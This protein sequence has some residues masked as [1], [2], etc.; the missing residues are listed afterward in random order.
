LLKKEVNTG[1]NI[2]KNEVTSIE[3]KFAYLKNSLLAHG[4]YFGY[5]IK[6]GEDNLGC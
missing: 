2:V 3:D 6:Y 5:N 4:M 1:I